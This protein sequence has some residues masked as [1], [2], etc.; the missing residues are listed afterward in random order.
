MKYNY[1]AYYETDEERFKAI[2]EDILSEYPRLGELAMEAAKMEKPFWRVHEDYDS[3]SNQE[4]HINRLIDIVIVTEG[5][6]EYQEEY[7]RACQDLIKNYSSWEREFTYANPEEQGV[8]LVM[9]RFYEHQKD[10]S[11]PLIILK[12]AVKIQRERA[13]QKLLN[14]RSKILRAKYPLLGKEITDE[15]DAFS[16]T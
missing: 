7:Q 8:Y 16:R 1:T 4:N 14:D 6:P 9:Q 10:K 12:E 3:F 15:M 5:K 2:E 13:T 11:K